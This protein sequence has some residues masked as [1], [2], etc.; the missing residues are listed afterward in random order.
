MMAAIGIT[1]SKKAQER[2]KNVLYE[3]FD[4]TDTEQ[5]LGITAEGFNAEVVGSGGVL[6]TI[7]LMYK[8]TR[9][10]YQQILDA[11]TEVPY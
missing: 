9:E 11:L 5:L 3:M 7:P 8:V 1:P 2:I 6:V 4:V 10:Q